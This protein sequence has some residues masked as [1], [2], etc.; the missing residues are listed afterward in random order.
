M[1]T[2]S[3]TLI[4]DSVS[5]AGIRLTTM[6]LR[7]PR[8][9]HSEFM[10]HR[11]FSRNARSSRAVP[12][13]TMLREIETD[14]VV[15]LHWGANQKGMQADRECDA[16]VLM[17]E[18]NGD[19]L[20]E[21]DR[22]AAWLAACSAATRAA[23]SFHDAGYHKQVVNRLLEPFM[24]IDTL[25][26]ATEYANFLGLRDH[27]AAE[28]HIAMLAREMRIAMAASEPNTLSEG[29]WHLPYITPAELAAHDKETLIKVSV[30]RCAR[31]SYRPFDG[32]GSIEAE[33]ARHDA[34][35]GAVPMHA[36]PAEHQAVP[37]VRRSNGVGGYAG[38]WH[39]QEHG[40]LHGWRQ[41]R[42]MLRGEN[43]AEAA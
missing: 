2:I 39:P 5:P 32:S 23:Q 9:I 42:K 30:A 18:I 3:A 11:V 26:T 24:H 28:P 7:Y 21:H 34:L 13:E 31:I 33:I 40:N 25:V 12:V 8:F 22:E 15:P 37:D 10:T 17:L 16:P 14:P 29:E 1:T 4:A 20:S 36:S 19:I 43:L 6:H 38:W 35:V 41:Y 27:H